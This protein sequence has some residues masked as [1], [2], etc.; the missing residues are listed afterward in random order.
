[1]IT[2]E[3]TIPKKIEA[4]R[5]WNNKEYNK[6]ADCYYEAASIAKKDFNNEYLSN[7]LLLE[8][9]LA[10][11]SG[12]KSLEIEAFKNAI[13]TINKLIELRIDD[14]IEYKLLPYKLYFQTLIFGAEH[15]AVEL[16]LIQQTLEE[17]STKYKL[18]AFQAYTLIIAES[19]LVYLE[20]LNEDFKG[21]NLKN[22]SSR[23]IE[24]INQSVFEQPLENQLKGFAL[25][26]I[27]YTEKKK[28]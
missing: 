19:Y 28:N 14:R 3:N 23:I 15:K 12:S 6:A 9:Y 5:Y 22:L 26:I 25:D 24:I 7:C 4:E 27:K 10:L 16:H 18:S 8:H 21:I 11:I 20:S 13:T 1:M 2:V 17:H